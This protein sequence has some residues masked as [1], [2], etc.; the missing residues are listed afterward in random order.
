MEI[1]Q[2]YIAKKVV[3]KEGVDIRELG[4]QRYAQILRERI[5]DNI[6]PAI[7]KD[8]ARLLPVLNSFQPFTTTAN[9]NYKTCRQVQNL[10]KSHL[11]RAMIQ[12]SWERQAIHVMELLDCV[13]CFAP[14]D[15]QIGL[16]VPYQ[17]EGNHHNYEPDFIVRLQNG[18]YLILEIKGKAGK[19]HGEDQVL[20]KNAAAKK[21]VGSVNNLGR[22]GQWAFEI[23]EDL[24]RLR[25]VIEFH[26]GI[27]EKIRPFRFVDPTKETI[28][29]DCV[30]LTTIQAA[31]G[32]FSEEQEL[33]VYDVTWSEDWITWDEHPRFAEGM[34]VARVRG[35]SMEP[36]I[37]DGSYCLFRLPT[38]GT[39]QGKTVLVWHAGITDP[40]TGGQYT[41]KVYESEK[42]SAK[43][44]EWEHARIVLKPRNPDFTPIIIEP[45]D[46]GD[47][48]IVAEFVSIIP[49]TLPE[50]NR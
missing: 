18:A 45:N 1:V 27:A 21:W 25:N 12:S 17:Y 48:R 23:C 24:N 2:S 50:A 26:A 8:R 11:N 20:A 41:V 13:E 16:I 4:L 36:S 47:V 22:Y 3:L 43:D 14:N 37:P 6:L 28:W 7:S 29:R 10:V 19:I 32:R 15:R 33:P 39:R 49:T 35:K 38:A 30:P 5:R 44:G 9:V 42:R 34:F 31:A 46:E 40:H